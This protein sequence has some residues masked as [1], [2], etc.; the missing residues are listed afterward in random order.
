MTQ[1]IGLALEMYE[2]EGGREERRELSH[3]GLLTTWSPAY[4]FQGTQNI[5]K[6]HVLR[7]K[8]W[9]QNGPR[10]TSHL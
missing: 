3:V 5:K 10:S 2:R 7:K 1:K 9:D 8:K 4:V 6:P